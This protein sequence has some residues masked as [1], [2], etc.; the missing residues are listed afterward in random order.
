MVTNMYFRGAHGV[1]LVYDITD[2]KTFTQIEDYWL[3]EVQNNAPPNAVLMI[4]GNKCDL[5]NYA[6]DTSVGKDCAQMKK[7][8]FLETSAKE[9]TNINKA[10]ITLAE[11]IKNRYEHPSATFFNYNISHSFFPSQNLSFVCLCRIM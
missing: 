9:A 4:I 6:V 2:R 11:T 7:A 10:F 1:I 3:K 5:S 8:L